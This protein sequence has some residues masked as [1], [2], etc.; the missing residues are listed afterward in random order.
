VTDAVE[1]TLARR[2]PSWVPGAYRELA[3]VHHL[4]SLLVWSMIARLH[5]SATLVGLLLLAA[6]SSG[7]YTRA[8]GV[9]AA[10]VA[11]QGVTAPLRGRAVDRRPAARVLAVTSVVYGAGLAA[12]A[13]LPAFGWP[14]MA[15]AAFAVGLACPPAT[16]ASRAKVAQLAGGAARQSA[17]TVQATTNELVLVVGPAAAGVAVGIVGA[18][19]T[20]ALSAAAAALGGLGLARAL[21]RAG[22]DT[23]ARATT[24]GGPEVVPLRPR[25]GVVRLIG[26]MTVMITGFGVVNLTLVAWGHARGTPALGGVASAVWSAGSVLGGLAAVASQRAAVPLW[27]SVLLVTAGIAPLALLLPPWGSGDPWTIALV[28][29]TGGTVIPAALAAMYDRLAECAT[30]SR[31]AELFGWLATATTAASAA[32][33]PASGLLLDRWG[34]SAAMAAATIACLVAAVLA[35]GLP[36]PATDR[37]D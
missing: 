37:L 2:V 4:P 16:Q 27:R 32:A 30:P 35:G 1:D 29:A 13:L 28:L 24:E 19:S 3:A 15:V 26:A 20:V 12:L 14:V 33:G 11:G 9:T 36:A 8:G 6:D 25:T 34:P 5:L 21:R 17:Y 7:S 10:L 22:V 31:R 23:P 18:R